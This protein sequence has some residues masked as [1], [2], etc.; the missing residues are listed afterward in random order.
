[1]T[2]QIKASV[3]SNNHNQCFTVA[4]QTLNAYGKWAGCPGGSGPGYSSTMRYVPYENG[5]GLGPKIGGAT[6][7]CNYSIIPSPPVNTIAPVISGNT[8]ASSTLTSTSGTWTGVPTPTL[9][10][11]WYRGITLI[12]GQVSI[13]YVTQFVDIGQAITCKVTGTNAGGSAVA[14]S[15]IITPTTPPTV[16]LLDTNNFYELIGPN[17]TYYLAQGN[18][19]YVMPTGSYMTSFTVEIEGTNIVIDFQNESN[20]SLFTWSD[21]QS[22]VASIATTVTLATAVNISGCSRCMF[23]NLFMLKASYT[24]LGVKLLGIR[25][26]GYTI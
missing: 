9:T 18:T 21:N 22:R 4:N 16:L 24:P 15:N 26:Y 11:Q 25:I 3:G 2:T 14:T 1:M 13:T 23:T 8:V 17:G 19:L 10:Y 12:A 6:C 5:S 20:T 7:N